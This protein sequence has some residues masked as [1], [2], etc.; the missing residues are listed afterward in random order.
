MKQ[1]LILRLRYWLDK[2]LKHFRTDVITFKISTEIDDKEIP[3]D[4]TDI[5]INQKSLF[6]RLKEYELS[7]ARRTKTNVELA[8]KYIGVDPYFLYRNVHKFKNGNFSAWQCSECRSNCAARLYCKVKIGLFFVYWYDFKQYATNIPFNMTES[9]HEAMREKTKWNYD[10]FQ[11]FK[12][13]KRD[14]FNKVRLLH[15]NPEKFK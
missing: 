5:I 3:W 9:I 7:E 4:Y 10:A 2:I 8:G 15:N 14:F 11:S 13:S 6:E 12:F 1:K